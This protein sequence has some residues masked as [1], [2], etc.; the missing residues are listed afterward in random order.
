MAN[1]S[2]AACHHA[3]PRPGAKRALR[4]VLLL[5]QLTG[6]LAPS[7]FDSIQ[8]DV[9]ADDG[10]KVRSRTST[11]PTARHTPLHVA[12]PSRGSTPCSC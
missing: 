9:A 8:K 5:L 12:T 2:S 10:P 6:S 1:V 4:S 7:V 11:L 3:P